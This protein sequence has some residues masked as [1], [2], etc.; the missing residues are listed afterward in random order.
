ML[1]SVT[2][3]SCNYISTHIAKKGTLSGETHIIV[4]LGHK[5]NNLIQHHYH[6]P[7]PPPL[8]PPTQHEFLG[9]VGS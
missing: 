4:Q 8:P 7:T 6:T 9:L 2:L 1:K 5:L 3:E